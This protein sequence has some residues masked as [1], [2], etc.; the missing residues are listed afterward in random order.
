MEKIQFIYI[1][2]LGIGALGLLSSL[3]LGE[4][5]HGDL[6]GH[7]FSHDFSGDHGDAGDADS[8]KLFSLRII[9][10]FLMAFGIGGGSMYLADKS[11]GVQIITGFLSGVVTAAITYYIMKLLYSQQGNSNLDA[12]DFIG[13]QASV[14]VETTNS[15]S[16]QI[17]ID[18]GGGDQL[19]LAKE[20]NSNP[21]KLHETVKIVGRLGSVLIIEKIS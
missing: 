13:K 1:L 11:I 12:A 15:G 20:K 21:V 17:K 14:T 8:P 4:F 18:S 6:G 10:A 7:D 16:C 5:G 9:F 2:F 19:F 3:I